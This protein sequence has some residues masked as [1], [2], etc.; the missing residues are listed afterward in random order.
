MKSKIYL[1]TTVLA[2]GA[3][4]L[5]MP[6]H[7]NKAAKNVREEK[8]TRSVALDALQFLTTA[9]SYPN[10]DIPAAAYS[11]AMEWYRNN[12]S[13]THRAESGTSWISMGPTNMGGR[14]IAIAL[15]PTDSSVIWLGSAGGGLWKS[16]T[17]GIGTNAWTYVPIGFPVLGVSSI[18]INPLNNKEMY[19]GTGEVYSDSS[20]S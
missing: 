14:T 1:F 12:A 8:E 5:C 7:Q 15:D 11:N 17:G 2:V 10:K 13:N 20:Y 9:A 18:A 19:I 4:Y 6:K 3:I 16:T